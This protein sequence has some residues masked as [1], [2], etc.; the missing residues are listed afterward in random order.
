MFK[1]MPSASVTTATAAKPGPRRSVR[2]ASRRSRANSSSAR[3]PQA[4][5][6]VSFNAAAFPNRRIAA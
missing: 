1:P 2:K 6:L 4:S 5:L 3:H